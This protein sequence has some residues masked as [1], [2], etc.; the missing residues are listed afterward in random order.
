MLILAIG[1]SALAVQPGLSEMLKVA[2]V[3]MLAAALAS[4]PATLRELLR[5]PALLAIGLVVL[6]S[7]WLALDSAVWLGSAARAQGALIALAL[8][9]LAVAAIRLSARDRRSIHVAVAVLGGVISVHVLLQRLG[10]DP[11]SWQGQL[12]QRP[13]AT[14]SNATILAGWLLLVLPPT[15]ALAARC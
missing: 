3:S 1:W 4:Q 8:L 7:S 6:T 10:L 12:D 13:S 9:V 11:L 5:Q 2:G 14:L 15:S